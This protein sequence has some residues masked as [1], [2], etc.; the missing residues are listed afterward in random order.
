MT[1]V[2]ICCSVM[3]ASVSVQNSLAQNVPQRNDAAL[4]TAMDELTRLRSY[5]QAGISFNQYSDR[6]LTA[7]GN[8]DVA[9]SRTTDSIAKVKIEV[10]L[11][12]YVSAR[13][14]WKTCIDAQLSTDFCFDV[15][16]Y[17]MLGAN[18]TDEAQKYVFADETARRRLDAEESRRFD[19]AEKAR[20]KQINEEREQH[21]KIE[22]QIENIPPPSP[23]PADEFREEPQPLSATVIHST[24]AKKDSGL[25]LLRPGDS[26]RVL[27][28]NSKFARIDLDG[29]VAEIPISDTDLPDQK[30]QVSA[31]QAD[32]KT[33]EQNQNHAARTTPRPQGNYPLAHYTGKPGFFYSPYTG[34]VYDLRAIADGELV[35]DLDTGQSFR[36]PGPKTESPEPTA[37]IQHHK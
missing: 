24:W 7:K 37:N 19:E 30:Y 25:R 10:A 9:L 21:R 26:V 23:T 35:L 4:Q 36:K 5:T 20:R 31:P 28:R 1:R 22:E 13:D 6:L 33:V 16:H 32:K 29:K 8:I 15:E 18:A 14:S 17:W 12:W 2:V 34:R 27:A 11:S 3:L